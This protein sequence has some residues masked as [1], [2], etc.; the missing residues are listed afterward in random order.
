MIEL[1]YSELKRGLLCCTVYKDCTHCPLKSYD[2]NPETRC[3][4]HLMSAAMN[5]IN[6]ME[7]DLIDVNALVGRWEEAAIAHEQEIF[8]LN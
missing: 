7:K 5:C 3:T 8:K 6:A 1:T 4:Y 2:S